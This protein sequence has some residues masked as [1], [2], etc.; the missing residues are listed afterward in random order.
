[1]V[2]EYSLATEKDAPAI[3]DFQIKMAEETENIKLDPEVVSLGVRAVFKNSSLGHYYVCRQKTS[4]GGLTVGSL[5]IVPEWSDWRNGTVWWIHSVYILPEYR[6]QGLFSK[7][8]QF[9]QQAVQGS[10]EL[11]G[12]RLYCDKRNHHAQKVY[13]KIGMSKEHYDLFEWLKN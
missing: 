8:Y 10:S 2:F 4:E 3:I 5:L 1:M 9:I 6:G 11:R 13:Q 7:F 12:L